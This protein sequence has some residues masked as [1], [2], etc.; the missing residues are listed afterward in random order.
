MIIAI[1]E[2]ASIHVRS[3]CINYISMTATTYFLFTKMKKKSKPTTT[4]TLFICTHLTS[5]TY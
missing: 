1:H 4:L 3:P 2:K 5:P